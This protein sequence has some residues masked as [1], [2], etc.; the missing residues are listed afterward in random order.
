M[1][2]EKA[3]DVDQVLN[4]A[5]DAFWARGYEATSMQDLVASTGVNRASLY[6]TYGDKHTLFLKALRMYDQRQRHAQ[7]T[8]LEAG[9][10]PKAAIRQLFE[11]FANSVV[12]DGVNKGCF[13]TNTA[14][15][16]AARD[17]EARQVV[18][19]AQEQLEQFFGRMVKAGQRLGE[20]SPDL[21]PGTTA[22]GLLA[23]LLGL[24]VLVRSRPHRKILDAVVKDAMERLG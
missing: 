23:T 1:P 8:H 3:F 13:M 16:L 22:S 2:W 19:A 5:M 14:L 9:P 21:H 6:A 10:S 15:E 18:A 20:I 12:E 4:K 24:L 11:A 17:R 7:L